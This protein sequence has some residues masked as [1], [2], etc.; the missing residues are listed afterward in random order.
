MAND[1]GQRIYSALGYKTKNKDVPANYKANL[2]TALGNHA[3][4]LMV[5]EG[6]ITRSQVSSAQMDALINPET[7]N[8][9]LFTPAQEA[10]FRKETFVK[11]AQN[12]D[13]SVVDKVT[14]I[15]DAYSGTKNVLDNLFGVEAGLKDPTTVAVKSQQEFT[16]NTTQGIPRNE[17]VI[18]NKQNAGDYTI[19]TEMFNLADSLQDEIFKGII[20]YKDITE[21][22]THI[23]DVAS[24]TAKN[25]SL[26][27]EWDSVRNFVKGTLLKY[28]GDLSTVI[29]F[30][31]NVQKQ[32]RMNIS[33]NTVNPQGSKVHRGLVTRP[34]WE[35]KVFFADT[36]AMTGFHLRVAE[37]FGVKT[38]T[39]DYKKAITDYAQIVDTAVMND[40]IQALKDQIAGKTF[41]QQALL[42]GVQAGG[43]NM[44]TL[45]ALL[46]L[47]QHEIALDNNQESFTTRLTGE[48]D[49]VNN[50]AM[51]A[52]L[53]LGGANNLHDLTTLLNSGGFYQQGSG[54]ESFNNWHAIP[55]NKDLYEKT[56]TS[57]GTEVIRASTVERDPK[58]SI[59]A[60]TLAA[61]YAFTG[62]FLDG[63]KVLKAGRNIVKVPILS[64][65]FGSS[66]NT[67][68][69]N[70]ADNFYAGIIKSIVSTSLQEK[71]HMPVAQINSNLRTLG[72][73]FF[74]KDGNVIKRDLAIKELMAWEPSQKQIE[75][76][77]QSFVD[78]V[79][80]AMTTVMNRDFKPFLDQRKA[81]NQAADLTFQLYNAVREDKY[82]QKI[83]E[84]MDSGEIPFHTEKDG[85]RT[86]Y[87]DMTAAQIDALEEELSAIQPLMHT[88]FSKAVND[89]SSGLAISK[90]E[91]NL[92]QERSYKS[93]VVLGTPLKDLGSEP[94]ASIN[95]KGY[96]INYTAPGVAMLPISTHSGDSFTSHTAIK[97][98]EV[99][100]LHDAHLASM[101]ELKQAGTD[102]NEALHTYLLNYS[103]PTEMRN[104]LMRVING[105]ELMSRKDNLS[106]K[107]LGAITEMLGGYADLKEGE[108]PD[109]ALARIIS[110]TV[111]MSNH[112][113]NLRLDFLRNVETISQ[114]AVEGGE[115]KVTDA[116]RAAADKAYKNIE[117][118]LSD[119]SQQGV[120]WLTEQIANQDAPTDVVP[121]VDPEAD[122]ILKDTKAEAS[123]FGEIGVPAFQ[124]DEVLT[125]MFKATPVMTAKQVMH[126]LLEGNLNGF[127]KTLVQALLKAVPRD[128]EV[129]YVTANTAPKEVLQAPANESRGWY[130]DLGNGK[131]AI[132][133]LGDDFKHA[134][135]QVETLI[136]EL[137]H[138]VTARGIEAGGPLVKELNE[139]F[140]KVKDFIKENNLG[141]RFDLATA[142]VDEMV[143]WGMSNAEF[144]NEVL[145]QIPMTTENGGFI[146]G[147]QK[148]I[149][150]LINHFFKGA[151]VNEK[152]KAESGMNVLITNV[153]GLFAQSVL[154]TPAQ[155]ELNL[156]QGATQAVNTLSTME[157]YNAFKASNNGV[158]VSAKFDAQLQYVLDSISTK[159]FG[160]FGS[161]KES[162]MKD[163]A[164]SEMQ[165]YQK[166]VQEGHAPFASTIQASGI[167]M[168]SQ[169][170]FV[171]EQVEATM[172][173]G[174]SADA[175]ATTTAYRELTKLYNQAETLVKPEHFLTTPWA[176]ATP[177]EQKQATDL[178]NFVFTVEKGADGKTN[179]LA[180]FA[181]LGMAHEQFN[182]ILSNLSTPAQTSQNAEGSVLARI[183]NA[184]IS[185]VE[186]FADKLT[187]V[188][189]G[190]PADKQLTALVSTIVDIEAKRRGVL[191]EKNSF[192]TQAEPLLGDMGN[193]ARK[194]VS[195]FVSQ[196]YFKEHAQPTVRAA[197]AVIS[198]QVNFR[199]LQ[200]L[201]TIKEL[202]AKNSK[203]QLGVLQG[204]LN[205]VI[206]RTELNEYMYGLL[207]T[208]K[209]IEQKREEL[210]VATEAAVKDS[211]VNKGEDLTPEQEKAMAHVVLRGDMATLLGRY[212]MADIEGF[213][214]S[215]ALLS[216]AIAR[217]ENNLN[218][219]TLAEKYKSQARALGYYL[220]TNVSTVPHLQLNAE[221]IA[222]NTSI[223]GVTRVSAQEV[224]THAPTIDLLASLYAIKYARSEHIAAAKEVFSKEAA[225]TDG[226]NGLEVM[227]RTHK[228]LQEQAKK[229]NF[230]GQEALF[231]K[232]YTPD[233]FNPYMDIAA[234]SSAV[235]STDLLGISEG[236]QLEYQGYSKGY[237]LGKDSADP[238][239]ATTHLYTLRDGGLKRWLSSAVSFT[240]KAAKGTSAKGLNVSSIDEF[241]G[242]SQ[243]DVQRINAAKQKEIAAF[244]KVKNFD[245][246]LVTKTYLVP[247]V[248]PAGKTVDWRYMMASETKNNLLERNNQPGRLL[249]ALAGNILDKKESKT[250]NRNV[251]EA[252]HESYKQDFALH[253]KDYLQV[254]ASASDPQLQ[255]IYRLLSSDMKA[256]I[257]DVWGR[258]SMWVRK[259]ML[260]ITFGY[261]KLSAASAFDKDYAHRSVVEKLVTTIAEQIW[262]DVQINT[263]AG[264]E[265]LP[266][267]AQVR[268][269]QTEDIWQALVKET[270]SNWVVKSYSTL[271]GNFKSN[272]SLLLLKG[273]N[274]AELI[275]YHVEAFKA[276]T[277]FRKDSKI[278]AA[279]QHSLDTATYK[280]T[281]ADAEKQK[282]KLENEL[283]RN[284]AA[285]L[286]E[287]GLLPSIVEDVDTVR[288]D[289]HSYKSRFVKQTEKVTDLINP[290]VLGIGK[291]LLVTEDTKLYKGLSFALQISDFLAR[292]ALYKH[293]IK[294]GVT[295]EAAAH[296]ASETF[297]SYDAPTHRSIQALNDNGF[298]NFTKYYV[299]IQKVILSAARGN[300]GR[301]LALLATGHMVDNLDSVLES[302]IVS[303]GPSF[304]NGAFSLPASYG[305]VTPVQL[306]THPF[307]SGNADFV[308]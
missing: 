293:D 67:S 152:I 143:A 85:S 24:Q 68:V 6:L 151:S 2:I 116:Q 146:T 114:Y 65:T 306:L 218:T 300:P 95:T 219:S 171:M 166:A 223:G 232:G 195:D 279:V 12:D 247:K 23:T 77:K 161:F 32:Q 259:D 228:A 234:A 137:V 210:M 43:E 50:G 100:Q 179:H 26:I 128:L 122:V 258:N 42:A 277:K 200:V 173:E 133:V 284:P 190:H 237:A 283:A 307:S 101:S 241:G 278:L 271:V 98:K 268:V 72:V 164:L 120:T 47:A 14:A 289:P 44:K 41:D 74:D 83:T 204:L 111:S 263:P 209:R 276:V 253:P 28:D 62:K 198:T 202:S 147:L 3:I 212:S 248:N 1:V 149:D 272:V 4:A 294:K 163:Q 110:A 144:Q 290:H 158:S 156:S 275:K 60:T 224:A 181:A 87:H 140:G 69:G 94:A 145:G 281:R 177:A 27:R 55:G 274:P 90:S 99:L 243:T 59:D 117:W 22:N 16:K 288:D 53:Q 221:N 129:R 105:L 302:S 235:Q 75:V 199:T 165:V 305:D 216:K 236:K 211:F 162:L 230:A 205:E 178:H 208:T 170:A 113:N 229:D 121:V 57:L 52:N 56:A 308:Q 167:A 49:G 84:L 148:L 8:A 13:G 185:V 29:H 86:P 108:T 9:G 19:H 79:G 141:S 81:F 33:T 63:D 233:M 227:L 168:T 115:F 265:T 238:N 269:R 96:N 20:G 267:K 252:L 213:V 30:E 193:A 240:G 260:D 191:V 245:P 244:D 153:A 5:R 192:V 106:D 174:L 150:S 304:S 138:A 270:K 51:L 70:M 183:E 203:G 73:K 292:Y 184:F 280:G 254:S 157:L 257:L 118:K 82:A 262:P 119:I 48:V 255:E 295:P 25:D 36:D 186:W 102:L 132:Y 180:R 266:G 214:N 287:A 182:T 66:T 130:V 40:A 31:H 189:K 172:R 10:D 231:S 285:P 286:I 93:T 76:I 104:A 297:I 64:V 78:T 201:E 207:R 46:A 126:K 34:S 139:L 38:D 187:G 251:V 169:E 21:E 175:I 7:G 127:N 301:Y 154:P 246:T 123:P 88:P 249:G 303:K 107:V 109:Q 250:Q 142:S 273:M 242:Q 39:Q 37:G 264:V 112:A 282:V 91:R 196:P 299:R 155:T 131:K 89:L 194:R 58:K 222:R 160:P 103:A 80:K 18:Q 124:S 217:Q 197:A 159:V 225:R 206:G 261:R 61:V 296:N 135:L 35:Q 71:G 92:S 134:N 125:E 215:P 291:F 54:H 256:D 176:Q 188:N 298:V 239:Q 15:K 17:K 220:V 11:V 136:H 97:G 226:G 45:E